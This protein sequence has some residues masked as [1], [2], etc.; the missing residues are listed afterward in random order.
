[1]KKI[2]TFITLCLFVPL[3]A[4]HLIP[5][6]ELDTLQASFNTKAECN[7]M[8]TDLD[9]LTKDI[10]HLKE[11]ITKDPSAQH[12]IKKLQDLQTEQLNLEVNLK[13]CEDAVSK[14]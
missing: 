4:V 5:S 7:A 3:K 14:K 9:D 10:Q 8:K 2:L 1:M 12:R 13:K 6:S 11:K